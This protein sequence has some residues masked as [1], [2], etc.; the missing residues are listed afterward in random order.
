VRPQLPGW[1]PRLILGRR[2]GVGRRLV[3]AWRAGAR[4]PAMGVAMLYRLVRAKMTVATVMEISH[5]SFQPI[6]LISF[7]SRS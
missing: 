3:V 1:L 6:D 5:A 7:A 2:R 4:A